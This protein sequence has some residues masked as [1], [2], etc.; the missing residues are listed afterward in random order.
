MCMER[1]WNANV[2]EL[3]KT[4]EQKQYKETQNH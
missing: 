3:A 4:C 1:E 2:H